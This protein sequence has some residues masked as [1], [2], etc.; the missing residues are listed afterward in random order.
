MC[1]KSFDLGGRTSMAEN[2]K[3]G[4]AGKVTTKRVKME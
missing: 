2:Q 1:T 3:C 4:C